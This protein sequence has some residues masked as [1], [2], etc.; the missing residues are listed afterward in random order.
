M[1]CNGQYTRHGNT[2]GRSDASTPHLLGSISGMQDIVLHAAKDPSAIGGQE[3]VI[4]RSAEGMIFCAF[5]Y[6]SKNVVFT[7]V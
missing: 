5:G 1:V 6:R 3:P 7:S 2:P 4:E